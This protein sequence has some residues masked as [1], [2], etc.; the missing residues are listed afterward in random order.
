M[1]TLPG[2]PE[3]PALGPRGKVWRVNAHRSGA[4]RCRR[5]PRGHQFGAGQARRDLRGGAVRWADLG[6]QE[7][8]GA[9]LPQP[10]RGGRGGDLQVRGARAATL[11]NED[12]P[13]PGTIV[14]ISNGKAYK[15]ASIRP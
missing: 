11:G 2:G 8:S 9:A 3:T 14:K 10:P 4:G 6:D 5:V 7:R 1:T 13:A 15:Q 12:P